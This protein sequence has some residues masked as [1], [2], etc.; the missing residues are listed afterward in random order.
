MHSAQTVKSATPLVPAGFFVVRAPHLPLD[1]LRRWG[2]GLTASAALA[3]DAHA[4][5]EA[6]AADRVLLRARL[7][8]IVARPEV[9]EAIHV[10]SPS[11]AERLVKWRAEPDSK[12][13]AKVE[14]ALVRYIAR[15]AGRATPFGLFASFSVGRLGETTDIT[16]TGEGRRHV[17][18]DM[19]YLVALSEAL[20]REPELR[21][22]ATLT[23]NSAL[24]EVGGRLHYPALRM[25]DGKR[26]YELTALERDEALDAALAAAAP[27]ARREDIA[28]AL[29]PDG[30]DRADARAYVDELI[31]ARVLES[32]LA[33]P[34]TG[35]EPMMALLRAVGDEGGGTAGPVAVALADVAR[36]VEALR[37][38]PMG[39]PAASYEAIA[40]RLE[41]LPAPVNRAQ[42]FQVDM[43]R[44]ATATLGRADAA[45]IA[46]GMMAIHA[47]ATPD[48]GL[49]SFIKSF[50]QRYES[51]EVPLME[52]LDEEVGIGFVDPRMPP[53]E[54]APLIAK[55]R[56]RGKKSPKEEPWT[57]RSR[58]LLSK[59]EDAWAKGADALAITDAEL[60]AAEDRVAL[61]YSVAALVTVLGSTTDSGPRRGA[62]RLLLHGYG[63]TSAARLLGRFCPW[64]D[65]LTETLRAHLREEE[66]RRPDAVFAELVHLPAGSRVAN[67]IV[68]PLLRDYEIAFCGRSGAP[69]QNVLS[70]ADLYLSH[71]AGRLVLRSRRLGREVVPRLSSAHNFASRQLGVYRFLAALQAQ[72]TASFAAWSWGPLGTARM[73][74]RVE[75]GPV[76]L[77]PRQWLIDA[78]EIARLTG[79]TSVTRFR[80]AARLRRQRR[81]PRAVGLREG[82]NVLPV[83][84]ESSLSLDAFA[85]A[86]KGEEEACLIELF[87]EPDDAAV[88]GPG[89]AYANELVVPF[90]SGAPRPAQAAAKKA[91]ATPPPVRSARRLAPGSEWLFAK[92]YGAR[93]SLDHLLR[94]CIRPVVRASLAG[95]AD[96]WF[97]LRYGDPDPHLR[98]RFHGV[99]AVLLANV[100][101]RLERALAPLLASGRVERFELGT[102]EREIER[103][104]GDVGMEIC[105]RI[106]GVDSEAALRVVERLEGRPEGR[107]R[108]AVTLYGM[109]RM[110]VDF[111]CD[112]AARARLTDA[113][114]RTF[115]AEMRT[116]DEGEHAVAARYR[117]ERAFVE[118]LLEGA[119]DPTGTRSIFDARSTAFA[120]LVKELR[121]AGSRLSATRDMLVQPLLHMWCNRVLRAEARRHELVLH[122]F[123]AKHYASRLARR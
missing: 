117:G 53:V 99:P 72:G 8:A 106:F 34:L 15:M 9:A 102:Y 30:D 103:Y 3:G 94:T 63:G 73:L 26:H 86:L 7:R 23:P 48:P 51:R 120:P 54:P 87:H 58:V 37:A 52:A 46:A 11:L 91:A 19:E 32:S 40:T 84:L 119:T 14:G 112:L 17:R 20:E 69:R 42:L 33:P 28:A 114:R 100:L 76:I 13:G 61:P 12:D 85:A 35:E 82:D 122:A 95:D 18:L 90:V 6:L 60:G 50:S 49:A 4:L 62:R 109:H 97:F 47:F 123:L 80:E 113:A 5:E 68:R 74:P 41:A 66:L 92:I 57:A 31:D 59:L 108:W 43:S 64:D 75:L 36:A 65:A 79:G 45:Q 16:L 93:G 101:P 121:A 98:V 118:E 115:L 56:L 38:A 22:R 89:G 78:A 70:V 44:P 25:V 88:R 111:G 110:L 96:N 107:E 67:V 39:A 77:A 81:L 27:G 104:G 55:L 116:P 24:Y 71:R 105:E 29:V 2:E 1:D 10:A 83:D 21:A